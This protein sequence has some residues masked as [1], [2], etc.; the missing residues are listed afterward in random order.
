MEIN[1]E[2]EQEGM[3][4]EEIQENQ[5]DEART[6]QVFDPS[7][8]KYDVR[9]RRVTD[10]RECARVTLPK[11]LTAEQEALLETSRNT[12]QEIFQEYRQEWST[13]I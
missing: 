8:K 6:R 11:P 3:T 7:D 5:E 2:A 9:K 13:K 1:K 12:Q 10:L 4:E